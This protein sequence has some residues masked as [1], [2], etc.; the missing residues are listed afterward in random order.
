[1]PKVSIVLPVYNGERFLRE[2][3]DSVFAQTFSDWELIC[4]NDCS[5]DN[6]PRILEEYARKDSRVRVIHNKENQ[7]LPRSLNIGFGEAKGEFLTWTSDDNAYLP[8]ALQTMHDALEQNGNCPMVVADMEYID[9][10]GRVTGRAQ[11]FD[12]QKVCTEN[13]VGACFMYRR[14]VMEEIGGYDSSLFLVEDYEYWLRM[15]KHCG[16]FFHIPQI[17]YR[18]RFHESSLSATRQ[19]DVQMR[20][21]KLLVDYFQDIMRDFSDG[22]A[23][24]AKIFYDSA[25]ENI[26]LRNFQGTFLTYVPEISNDLAVSGNKVTGGII[27]WGAGEIGKKTYGKLGKQVVAFADRD[28]EKIGKCIGEVPIM[29]LA[30]ALINYPDA[31][32]MIAVRTEW[33]YPMIDSLMQYG[34]KKFA[35]AQSFFCNHF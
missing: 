19:H 2:S 31:T 21:L 22:K 32:I 27:I 6:T 13:C 14:V 12:R 1:M 23:K 7:R 8:E 26:D 30:D 28:K 3:I 15:R 29:P 5:T 9:D 24:L 10:G 34:V 11:P 33:I 35:V 18:Y 16:D 20:R 25:G 17:L 4:V